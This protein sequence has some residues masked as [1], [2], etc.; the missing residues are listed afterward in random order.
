MRWLID[1]CID[2]IQTWKLETR[3]CFLFSPNKPYL[4]W[5]YIHV[6]G[7][8]LWNSQPS[9]GLSFNLRLFRLF[10]L[11]WLHT[12]AWSLSRPPT[13]SWT[14]DFGNKTMPNCLSS[15]PNKCSPSLPW[16]HPW[17]G[18]SVREVF[19]W[20]LIICALLHLKRWQLCDLCQ[21]Q[22]DIGI[23]SFF[24]IYIL[25]IDSD[26]NPGDSRLDSWY[27]DLTTKPLCRDVCDLFAGKSLMLTV[28]QT[29]ASWAWKKTG[30]NRR[31]VVLKKKSVSLSSHPSACVFMP[32]FMCADPLFFPLSLFVNMSAHG[33]P[34]ACLFPLW[35]C[36]LMSLKTAKWKVPLLMLEGNG[37]EFDSLTALISVLDT[38]SSTDAPGQSLVSP[39]LRL[40]ACW[41]VA[42]WHSVSRLTG[43]RGRNSS[44][45]DCQDSQ[46]R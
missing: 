38:N 42:L 37:S 4:C 1:L 21:P 13:Q 45:M 39:E 24:F 28:T 10:R 33:S 6:A 27:R 23:D 31:G 9:A 40:T 5:Y 15:L 46:G 26:S 20:G 7:L 12:S 8:M 29:V 25:Q 44:S 14:S 35:L 36:L 22:L 34:C 16:V 3:T 32:V 30:A 11:G 19:W 41:Q 17:N 43:W 2:H 18:F